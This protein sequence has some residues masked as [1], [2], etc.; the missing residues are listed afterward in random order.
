MIF[1]SSVLSFLVRLSCMNLFSCD[2]VVVFILFYHLWDPVFSK[3][4]MTSLCFHDVIGDF[5]AGCH[6]SILLNS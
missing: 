4:M 3:V 6:H 1:S 2:L 5:P